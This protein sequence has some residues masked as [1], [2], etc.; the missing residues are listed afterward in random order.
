MA[1]KPEMEIVP[2]GHFDKVAYPGFAWDEQGLFPYF[3]FLPADLHDRLVEITPNASLALAIGSANWI[4]ARLAP[5]DAD[6]PARDFVQAMWSD[7]APGW[8]CQWYAPDA[9]TYVGPVRGPIYMAIAILHDVLD[10]IGDNPVIADRAAW[11]HNLALHVLESDAA[12]E[13]WFHQAVERLEQAHS[14]KLEGGREPDIFAPAFPR[15][16]PVS[17]EVLVP[18]LSYDRQQAPELLERF[19]QWERRIGN[20]FI[21]GPWEFGTDDDGHDHDHDDLS[22]HG[23]PLPQ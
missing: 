9:D 13:H 8:R 10:A 3:Y 22:G 15:G 20:P 11:M 16:G 5:F 17:P 1:E 23:V 2:A 12:Y 6:R 4:L 14:W 18:E 21:L 7:I 19:I